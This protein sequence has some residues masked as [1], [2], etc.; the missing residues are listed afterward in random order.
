MFYFVLFIIG[1]AFACLAI[2]LLLQAAAVAAFVAWCLAKIGF[3]LTGAVAGA[4][5]LD[6]VGRLDEKFFG[7]SRELEI[8]G[9]PLT[10]EFKATAKGRLA[11]DMWTDGRRLY[12]EVNGKSYSV[13]TNLEGARKRKNQL[14]AELKT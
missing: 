9:G 8:V 14:L 10:D 11:P 12:F 6:V 13:K 5:G 7:I 4:G 3:R 1:I 2:W